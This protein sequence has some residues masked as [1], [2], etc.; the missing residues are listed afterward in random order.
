M[1]LCDVSTIVFFNVSTLIFGLYA[2]SKHQQGLHVVFSIFLFVSIICVAIVGWAKLSNLII[3]VPRI[4]L[5]CYETI[6]M[7][8][9]LPPALVINVEVSDEGNNGAKNISSFDFT[10]NITSKDQSVKLSKFNA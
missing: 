1:F 5:F 9:Y 4:F 7:N 3:L 8:T 2:L 10:D 6:V